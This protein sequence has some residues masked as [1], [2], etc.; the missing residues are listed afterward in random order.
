[1]AI[2]STSCGSLPTEEQVNRDLYGN[3]QTAVAS[4]RN[5]DVY[6]MGR[7]FTAG[8]LT[9]K[10]PEASA[11]AGSEGLGAGIGLNDPD[12]LALSYLPNCNCSSLQVTLYSHEAWDRPSARPPRPDL[13][14]RAVQV[15]GHEAQL[16]TRFDG[17][18]VDSRTIVVDYGRTV[19]EAVT[20][21]IFP[22]PVKGRPTVPGGLLATAGPEL[23]PLIDETTFLAVMQNLRPY[24]Q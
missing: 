18:Q 24:P 20:S 22:A 7:E 17:G 12:H 11:R 23:N 15:N 16:R 3:F 21:S 4:D 6:W 13:Q 5:Y 8:G 10:G 9:Y 2:I 14:N 1:M 19:V